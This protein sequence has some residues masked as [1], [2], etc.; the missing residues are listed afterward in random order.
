M[1]RIK[2]PAVRKIMEA[3]RTVHPP[4]RGTRCQHVPNKTWRKRSRNIREYVKGSIAC[5]EHFI[6]LNLIGAFEM[7]GS[8]LIFLV[9]GTHFRIFYGNFPVHLRTVGESPEKVARPLA[10]LNRGF[11]TVA[12]RHY[13]FFSSGKTTIYEPSQQVSELSFRPRD[14]IRISKPLCNL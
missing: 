13:E 12:R 7:R 3:M 10:K 14:E 9:V 6:S 2:N 1:L 11:Y 8:F 4:K 5:E